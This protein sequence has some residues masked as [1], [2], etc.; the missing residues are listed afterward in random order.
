VAVGANKT[1]LV[2]DSA[3]A[4][5]VKWTSA[6]T[7]TI[8]V[9]P[10]E[11]WTVSATAAGSTVNFDADTQGVFTTQLHPLVTGHS[12]SVALVQLLLTQN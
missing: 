1:I 4:A 12:M 3:E 10:E 5:G 6:I 8:L 2:A 9:S 11:R 7:D